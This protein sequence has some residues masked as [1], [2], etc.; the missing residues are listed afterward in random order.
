MLIL[1]YTKRMDALL[2][3]L[4]LGFCFAGMAIGLIIAKKTLRKGCSIDPDACACRKE[5]KDPATCERE[6]GA[7][8]NT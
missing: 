2:T 5:G 6:S 1:S 4:V 7:S 8:T 3:I